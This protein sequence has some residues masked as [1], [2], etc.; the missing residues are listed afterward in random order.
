MGPILEN[1]H[2][3]SEATP[4]EDKKL[5]QDVR[6]VTDKEAE[7]P[8]VLTDTVPL[9]LLVDRVSSEV[10]KELQV[11]AETCVMLFTIR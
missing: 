7:L 2:L 4:E 6:D 3:H 1:G 9:G 8:V 10:Y 5:V 11:L